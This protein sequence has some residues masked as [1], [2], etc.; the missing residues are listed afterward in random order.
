MNEE[1]YNLHRVKQPACTS[2]GPTPPVRW[3]DGTVSFRELS[4]D[5]VK[6][7]QAL[8]GSSIYIVTEW[9]CVHHKNMVFDM[10]EVTNRSR[11]MKVKTQPGDE[12]AQD[13]N[14]LG[15]GAGA[16]AVREPKVP[17]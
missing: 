13:F 12:L 1:F 8:S 17:F 10:R 11:A 14:L 2:S 4:S 7:V 15:L 3:S 5:E 9:G 16:S 6:V